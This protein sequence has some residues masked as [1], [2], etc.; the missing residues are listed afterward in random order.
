MKAIFHTRA[1][2]HPDNGTVVEILSFEE[3]SHDA[4]GPL[5]EECIQ[6][7][8]PKIGKSKEEIRWVNI[9]HLHDE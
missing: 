5:P 3:G 7:K 8:F 9:A 6:V 2:W 1:F 4:S